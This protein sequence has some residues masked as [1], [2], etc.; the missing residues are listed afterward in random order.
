MEGVFPARKV[1]L[2]VIPSNPT[3]ISSPNSAT[4]I[5]LTRAAFLPLPFQRRRRSSARAASDDARASHPLRT[6]PTSTPP[7][8]KRPTR[9]RTGRR[10]HFIFRRRSTKFPT[11]EEGN[12][13]GLGYSTRE[14]EGA[15]A[16]GIQRIRDEGQRRRSRHRR[17]HRRGVRKDRRLA[18]QRHHHA[19]H[20]RH[21]AAPISP[22]TSSASPR[23]SSPATS[24][25]RE[26]RVRSSPTAISSPS[27]SISSSSPSCSSSSSRGSTC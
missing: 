16:E 21:R 1:V 17:D 9:Y 5:R 8:T 13:F 25:T 18:G 26:S 19:V 15:N 20:R 27:R 22:I 24:P 7:G 11:F 4:L 23:Q 12:F 10:R 2:P 3:G 14:Q 6:R